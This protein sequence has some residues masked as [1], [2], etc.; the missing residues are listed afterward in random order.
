MFG[1][2]IAPR[3]LFGQFLLIE[4][5]SY[6]RVGG[7]AAVSGCILENFRLGQHLR[8]A[9]VPLHCRSGCGVFSFRMYPQG[10]REMIDGWIKGFASGA[11][12]TPWPILLLVIA[13]LTGLI[14]P[15]AALLT[16][17]DPQ[18]WLAVYGLGVLQTMWLLHR[19]GRFHWL[20]AVFYPAP[21]IFY[22]IIFARSAYRSGRNKTV[23]WKG[24]QICAD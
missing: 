11:G 2:W 21:L 7:H 18:L 14:L 20:T 8:A 9:G 1:D 23:V 5:A 3:G 6:D 4:R 16:G 22:F 10:W 15:F 13:W 24:R 17:T 19:V 12:R